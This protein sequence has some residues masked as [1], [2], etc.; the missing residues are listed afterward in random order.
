MIHWDEVKDLLKLCAVYDQ[1]TVSV[2]DVQAWQLVARQT[3]WTP[4]AAQ[5]IIVDHYATGHD[6]P[7]ITPATISDGIRAARRRAVESF[8]APR[9]PDALPTADYPAWFRAQLAEHVNRVLDDWADG[10][11]IPA[12]ITVPTQRALT[13]RTP[14]Q[15]EAVEAVRAFTEKTRIPR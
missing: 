9:I 14:A 7:R 4:R 1:R 5:R 10:K 15:R 3:D 2:E 13:G 11:P 6:R 12:G 8:E